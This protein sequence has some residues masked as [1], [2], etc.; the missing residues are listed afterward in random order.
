MLN[1]YYTIFPNLRRSIS[2]R[3]YEYISSLDT[4][5][6]ML[7]MNYGFSPLHSNVK[8]LVLRPA[9]ETHRYSIQL[10]HHLASAIDLTGLDVL[11]VGSGRG[12]GASY[13][14]RYLRP[15][16]M[17]GV[18]ITASAIEFCRQHHNVSGLSFERHNA[19]ALEFAD[20]SFDV[21][22][23]VE[24]SNCYPNISNFF[25]EVARVLRPGGYFLY[26][27]LR[28]EEEVQNWRA[29]LFEIGLDL[30]KEENIT[31]NVLKA[32]ELD[33]ARKRNLIE[34]RA[35]K[36]IRKP[37][38]EFA[39]MKGSGYVYGPLKHGEKMYLNFVFRKPDSTAN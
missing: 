1:L 37:F 16:S 39:G 34:Q 10:Y 27:D 4:G 32:L 7:F 15:R 17:T 12:G 35:P 20:Q 21:I 26:T 2:K 9:D 19:E 8:K 23:N 36:F 14:S 30:V 24:S 6:D 25:S 28:K 3:W 13:I 38:Y 5:T 31:P 22:L 11:E 33:D 29:Q 18:D